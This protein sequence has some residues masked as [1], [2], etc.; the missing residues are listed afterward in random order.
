MFSFDTIGQVAGWDCWLFSSIEKIVVEL[1]YPT[2][3]APTEYLLVYF[4]V[5]VMT[6]GIFYQTIRCDNSLFNVTWQSV[7]A[8][9]HGWGS[10]T[11]HETETCGSVVCRSTQPSRT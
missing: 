8:E 11:R 7:G 5:T 1:T 4:T 9:L 2:A 6:L 3:S 10:K